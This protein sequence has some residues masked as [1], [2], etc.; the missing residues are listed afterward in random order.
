MTATKTSYATCPLCEATC[1]LEIVT[2]GREVLS[3]R[4]DDLDVFSRGYICPKA[5]SLKELDADRDCIREPM[6][7]R[8]DQWLNVSWDEAFAEIEQGLTPILQEHGRDALAIYAGNPNAHNLASLLYLPVLI[9]ASKSHN[10]YSAS[11]VDQMPKQVS[12][13]LMFGTVLSVPVPDLERTEYLLLLG[14]N[15]LVSNGSLMT[16]PDMRGRL[17]R[18]RQRG[19]KIV[20]IDPFR[21][22]TAQEAD[23]HHFIRPGYDAHLLF[24]M[25]HT[26]FAEGLVKPG[27][28]AE[29]LDGLEQVR[30]LAQFFAPEKV[31]A[32]CGIDAETIRTLARELAAAPRA[33]VY[34]RI[35]TCTQEFGTLAS[36]LVD[37]L[38]VLTGNL[39]REGGAMFTRAAAGSRNTIGVSGKGRGV[40]FGRW[41]SRVRGLPEVY[42]ELPA[43]CLAEEIETP[44]KGQVRALI[45]IA[46]NP[47]L[48]TPNSERLQQSLG[49]LDFM[50]SVD[51][52]LNETTRYAN[53]IL[54]PPPTLTHS[55][56][57]LALYQL[58]VHNVAHYSAPVLEREAGML[59]EWEILLRLAAI[60][61]GQGA[62]ADIQLIDDMSMSALIQ[63]EVATPGSNIEGRD[64][65]E[66]LS[67]LAPRRGS[68]RMLDFMLRSGPYGDGFGAQENGLSL[69]V[70]EALPHGVDLGPLQPRIP[71]ILRTPSGKIELA[72]PSFVADVDRLRSSLE[73]AR[74]KANGQMLLIGRRDLRSNNSWMHN[75]NVLTKGKERCTLLVHPGDAT[76]LA[77]VDGE[78]ACVT[79]R[80]GAVEIPVEV[81][82]AIMPGVV[83][84]PHGWGHNLPGT[85]MR[86]AREHAGVNTN[87]LTIAEVVDPLSG[88][89]VLNGVAVTVERARSS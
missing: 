20:V 61:G 84:I 64:P 11:T 62:Q 86:V 48:S 3:I 38:N 15:P 4:G 25:V 74:E 71:E 2:R 6:V 29:H 5:Y 27:R 44:G 63:R 17:R 1:G 67:A 33:A 89:A 80:A 12:A 31:A 75:L 16:A 23:A 87:I 49:M 66:L 60:L 70:L 69:A 28:L 65:A 34:G 50:V 85:R 68:E 39:D 55:H 41:K 14:A 58:A 53:V 77:L 18:L 82:D 51:M 54:P 36:W 35:G 9:H 59:D 45:T 13:G 73:R 26:L 78:M 56:Y 24:A 30:E 40:R 81:T 22:R 76:R 19:G 10:F 57:D 7:R 83:S 79:S 47:A 88:N 37:V 42:G 43:V 32:V 52:Y 46:G 72:H 8:G 21:T